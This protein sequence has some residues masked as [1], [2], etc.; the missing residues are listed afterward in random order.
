MEDQKKFHKTSVSYI[1]LHTNPPAPNWRDRKSRISLKIMFHRCLNGLL[2]N[3]NSETRGQI[4][5]FT[6]LWPL[7]VSDRIWLL[8]SKNLVVK[9]LSPCPSSTP[10][11]EPKHYFFL[12]LAPRIFIFANFQPIFFKITWLVD[13]TKWY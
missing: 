3:L 13:Y 10:R 5:L 12:T 4:V 6:L 9:T 1:Q 2:K 11:Y 7:K 8:W